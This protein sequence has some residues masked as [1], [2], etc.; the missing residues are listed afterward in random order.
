L[1]PA[2]GVCSITSS[3]GLRVAGQDVSWGGRHTADG[4]YAQIDQF[5]GESR[6]TRASWA[7]SR[8]SR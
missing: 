8:G 4:L 7:A 2:V 1:V 3:D 6:G 5:G